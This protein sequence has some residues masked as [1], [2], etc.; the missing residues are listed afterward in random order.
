MFVV[1]DI[2]YIKNNFITRHNRG[3]VY[4][5]NTINSITINNLLRNVIFTILY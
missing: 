1:I 2:G 3:E 4:N 5:K